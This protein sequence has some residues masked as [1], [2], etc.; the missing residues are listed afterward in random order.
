MKNM[1]AE[2]L[3]RQI[4]LKDIKVAEMAEAIGVSKKTIY[5][6]MN[7]TSFPSVDSFEKISQYLNVSSDYLLGRVEDPNDTI[8]VEADDPLFEEILTIRR[9]FQKMSPSER[10]IVQNL[11]KTIVQESERKQETEDREKE[12][13]EN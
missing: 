10:R 8:P 2:R 4:K 1:F 6:F 11:V 5:A 7:G 12:E 13:K 9:A 3:K